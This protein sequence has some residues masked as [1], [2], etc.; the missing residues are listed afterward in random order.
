LSC[1]AA[2]RLVLSTASGQNVD[3]RQDLAKHRVVAL[4]PSRVAVFELGIVAEVFGLERPEL[5]VPWWYSL[6]VCGERPGLVAAGA[7]AVQIDHG[8]EALGTADTVIVP[9][10]SG[11]PSTAL[12]DALRAFRGRVVSICSGVFLLAAA[13]LLAGREAATHWRYASELA[14]RFPDVRV[15]PDVLYVDGG[16]VLTS[17]GSA[18]GIDLCLHIV[19]RDHGSAI[20][21]AVARRLVIPPH[22]DGGQAQLIE[23]PVAARPDDDPIAGVMAWALERLD[24]PLALA[25]LAG[26]AYMS[27]RTFTRRFALATGQSPGRW[28]IEQRV[29]ASLALLEGSEPIETVAARVGFGSA[30]TYRHHFGAIM[31][32][33]PTAYRRAFYAAAS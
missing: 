22:R 2:S 29:R 8:L 5:D 23:L 20:A 3:V 21:N 10:W 17:A 9:G 31:R 4:V 27:V 6:T 32:T 7:F 28:L 13:G 1:L 30:A 12:L 15:N 14:A 18:A 24:E 11:E 33:T 25:T 26:R 19:R 16:D